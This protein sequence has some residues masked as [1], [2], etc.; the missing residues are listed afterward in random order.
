MPPRGSNSITVRDIAARAGVSV[1]TVSR[2]LSGPEK[3]APISEETRKRVI[4]I[5]ESLKFLPDVHYARLQERK[6]YIA[7][8]LIPRTRPDSPG[9]FFSD[10]TIGLFMSTLEESLCDHDYSILI[11]GVDEDFEESGRQQVILRNN[12]ADGLL[13][14]DAFKNPQTLVD[15]KE[16]NRP[17]ICVAFPYETAG[18]YIVPDNRQGALDMTRHLLELGHR[19]IAYLSGGMGELVDD[20]REGGYRSAMKEAGLEP[21]EFVGN[22]TVRGGRRCAEEILANHPEVTAVFAAND[23]MA[24]G[25]LDVARSAGRRVPD[26]LSI[27]G[28]DGTTHSE[29]AAPSL[30]TGRLPMAE[31]GRLAAEH[32]LRMIEEK[33]PEPVQLTLPIEIIPRAS[34]GPAPK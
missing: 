27:A 33:D 15:L 24:L 30:T 29:L 25:A 23:M 20:L 28:F 13:I 10:E 17:S 34:T 4:E 21:L 18:N 32:L 2:V 26:D 9:P 6:S 31:T 12:T 8:L 16:E 22:Y 1:S 5:C 14:W 3:S 19:R 11:Q 7:A